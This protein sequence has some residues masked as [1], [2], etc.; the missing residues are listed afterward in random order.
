MFFA[1]L[2]GQ[3][4]QLLIPESDRYRSQITPLYFYTEVTPCFFFFK[5]KNFWTKKKK[6]MDFIVIVKGLL[7]AW[8]YVNHQL[9]YPHSDFI[10]QL[11][12]LSPFSGQMN[13]LREEDNLRVVEPKSG[14][15][16][17]GGFLGELRRFSRTVFGGTKRRIKL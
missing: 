2:F 10:I 9:I 14:Q 8:Q 15:D 16:Q 1:L 17:M 7:C 4:N 3:S 6:P 13:R 12:L 5:L 11:P